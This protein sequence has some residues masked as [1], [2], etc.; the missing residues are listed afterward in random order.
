LK[1]EEEVHITFDFT[2]WSLQR[3]SGFKGF[4]ISSI[5]RIAFLLFLWLQVAGWV[6]HC[7]SECFG[8]GVTRVLQQTIL[9][10]AVIGVVLILFNFGS[11]ESLQILNRAASVVQRIIDCNTVYNLLEVWV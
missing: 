3:P 11:F 1:L 8:K 7:L 10:T 2:C 5:T 4:R 9:L 6:E